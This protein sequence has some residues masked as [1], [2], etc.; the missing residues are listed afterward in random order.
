MLNEALIS[1]FAL[2][3][4]VFGSAAALIV[5]PDYFWWQGLLGAAVLH[6]AGYLIYRYL[7][8]SVWPEVLSGVGLA[9]VGLQEWMGVWVVPNS[10][11]SLFTLTA[12]SA[13]GFDQ[14]ERLDSVA[15]NA[16]AAYY[17][18]RLIKNHVT[19]NN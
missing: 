19:W 8:K 13:V 6:V 16:V 9:T 18:C 7:D 3:G 4:V 12:V 5:R 1:R 15:L 10:V 14:L 2:Y 17:I 11:V